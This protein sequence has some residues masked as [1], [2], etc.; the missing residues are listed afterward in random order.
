MTLSRLPRARGFPLLGNLPSL[1]RDT[2]GVLVKT[3]QRCGELG[4][5]RVGLRPVVLITGPAA[6]RA[7]LV[8]EADAFEK[9]PVVR[10]LARPLLGDGLISCATN[11]HAGSQATSHTSRWTT[12]CTSGSRTRKA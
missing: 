12:S 4:V 5:F 10:R 1:W 2:A 3:A 9:G 6:A 11:E 7:V 8:D